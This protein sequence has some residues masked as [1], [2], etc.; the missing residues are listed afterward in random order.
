M[1]ELKQDIC[2]GYVL[3]RLSGNYQTYDLTV[4]NANH[5]ISEY[6][7]VNSQTHI[8]Y[9][10]LVEFEWV[11]YENITSRCRTGDPVL[12]PMCRVRSMSNPLL[13]DEGAEKVR[14]SNPA[15]VRDYFV[16]DAP[17]GRKVLRRKIIR[18]DGRVEYFTKFYLPAT[19]YDNPDKEFV[20]DYELRLLSRSEYIRQA[21]LYGNWYA[22][23]GSY[24][25][26]DWNPNYHICSPFKIPLHWKRFRSMD[27]GFKS[28]GC[29]L[30]WAMDDDGNIFCEKE[31]TFQYK[32]ADKV[33]KMIREIETG[34]G[35]W[36]GRKSKING[37][38]DDQLWE[39]R[40]DVGKTKAAVMAE[41]GVPWVKADKRSR[42]TNG[43]RLLTRIRDHHD[44]QTTPGIVFF[45]SCKKCIQTIPSIGTDRNNKECPAD[46]G[47]DHW[48]DATLYACAFASYGHKGIRSIP[49]D[50]DDDDDDYQPNTSPRSGNFGYWS[51]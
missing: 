34:L 29:V 2:K 35:L 7:L 21:L 22:Q 36:G 26:G 44:F 31:L 15:W 45:N 14:V 6:G 16:Q 19:L 48:H 30:W 27:W 51:H 8:A 46:G 3:L 40:G 43:L 24:Y 28:P 42:T 4:E 23:A 1:K 50:D 33:A 39:E 38:A 32:P 20:D 18:P 10:E 13:A 47:E 49:D 17:E 9:D 37:P 11:Q 25:G 5:Y 41:L 12:R